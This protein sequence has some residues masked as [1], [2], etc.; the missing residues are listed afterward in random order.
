[1]GLLDFQQE[2]LNR[3]KKELIL[4]SKNQIIGNVGDGRFYTLQYLKEN[5]YI[6]NIDN[7]KNE[8]TYIPIINGLEEFEKS[9]REIKVNFSLGLNFG[10]FSVGANIYSEE[11][12]SQKKIIL[13]AIQKLRS[14]KK[15]LIIVRYGD[16][17]SLTFK[18]LTQ[19][20]LKEK[21]I[22]F[23]KFNTVQIVY[24]TSEQS[25]SRDFNKVNFSKL[26]SSR[27]SLKSILKE[28]DLNDAIT[29]KL[30]QPEIEFI[31]R[32]VGNNLGC[33]KELI[34]SMNSNKLSFADN[35]DRSNLVYSLINKHFKNDMQRD[36][37]NNLLVYCSFSEDFL[38]S[39][40]DLVFLL[41]DVN[42]NDLKNYIAYAK[43]NK[44]IIFINDKINVFIV[45]LKNIYKEQF[46]SQK[47]KIYDKLC[48]LI[49]NL[50]PSNY[51]QKIIYAK[52]ANDINLD[53]Y[54]AQY[55]MQKIRE[56]GECIELENNKNFKY[57]TLLSNYKTAYS[58]M[59][60]KD[61]ENIE[62][63]FSDLDFL[64]LCLSTE[65]TLLISQ[66][67][68]KS[69]NPVKRNNALIKLLSIDENKL[70]GNLAYR[71]ACFKIV[72]YIHNGHYPEARECYE[73]LLK[74]LSD[75][76]AKH[77]SEEL[78][79]LFYTLCR[80]NNMIFDFQSSLISIESATN[81]FNNRYDLP[82]DKY[83]ALVNYFG[84]ALRNMDL[85][86]AKSA[87]DD[88]KE[89]RNSH[90][91]RNFSREYIFENNEIIYKYLT[92]TPIKEVKETFETLLKNLPES[93][94]KFLIANNCA[95]F[96]AL[97]GDIE[98]AIAILRDIYKETLTDYEGVYLFRYTINNSIFEYIKDN[99]KAK[100]LQEDLNKLDLNINY[101]NRSYML[102]ERDLTVKAM[103]TP[104]ANAND[105]LKC[106]NSLLKSYRP[107]NGY[108]LG[109]AIIPLFHWSD[110]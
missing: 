107:K 56:C 96:T 88:I 103:E 21:K 49:S 78:Q 51:R 28:M 83:F 90:C 61:Y 104:C 34:E 100:L 67:Q 9:S 48:S 22:A 73:F 13:K 2:N 98:Q 18:L 39:L 5:Y 93:A 63:L 55:Y 94:D 77:P 69:L 11:R 71:L 40:N 23:F 17:N 12:E 64:P 95:V 44:L 72:A 85:N 110:D 82:Q 84:I 8:D 27:Q 19:I 31:F 24:I 47:G 87:L 75:K 14:K 109:F 57:Y 3:I 89:L 86:R 76:I 97:S 102:K 36:K 38:L 66:A 74:H 106:F 108:E 25:Q 32:L 91:Y 7:S 65:I 50:Y 29:E 41:N 20:D 60:R 79:H 70:D 101:P 42:L 43:D 53:I 16:L 58:Y 1:M 46:D 30:T 81:Y 33:L 68:T 62:N 4:N 80:K 59:L 92:D 54:L 99:K 6:I 26:S 45:L 15:I 35:T 105:W 37:I 10:I 52:L